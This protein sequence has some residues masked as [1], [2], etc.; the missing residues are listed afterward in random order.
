MVVYDI[1]GIE[2]VVYVIKSRIS[3]NGTYILHYRPQFYTYMYA[4]EDLPQSLVVRIFLSNKIY[5]FMYEK[6]TEKT[7]G[8][9][10]LFPFVTEV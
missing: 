4:F 5:I 8:I 10:F 3:I 1:F 7:V 6:P 2:W 9:K